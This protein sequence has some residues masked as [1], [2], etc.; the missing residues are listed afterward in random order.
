MKLAPHQWKLVTPVLAEMR[1][2]KKLSLY[3]LKKSIGGITWVLHSGSPWADIPRKYAS[4]S[5]CY[6][7]YMDLLHSGNWDAILRILAQHLSDSAGIHFM[8]CFENGKFNVEC[9]HQ[10]LYPHLEELSAEKDWRWYTLFIFLNPYADEKKTKGKRFKLKFNPNQGTLF[11]LKSIGGANPNSTFAL[12]VTSVF[13][14][15]NSMK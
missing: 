7:L 8:D 9:A 10:N 12:K 11:P 4:P 15:R 5:T 1:P 3:S 14:E 2:R 13:S 6:K